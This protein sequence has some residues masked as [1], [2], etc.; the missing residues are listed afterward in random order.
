MTRRLTKTFKRFIRGCIPYAL[1]RL[2]HVKSDRMVYY[3]YIIEHGDAHHLFLFR[4]E[5]DD[6]T[7]ELHLDTGSGLFYT[8]LPRSHKKLF[9][10]RG[11]TP[12]K[13]QAL[14]K[15][16]LMEQDARSPHR[17][18]DQI[19]EFAGKVL[20]D[21]GAAEGILSLMAIEQ[22]RHVYLFECE[23]GWDEALQKTFEPWKQ[24]VSIIPK[25]VCNHDD[26]LCLK[27]DTFCQGLPQGPL[28]LKMDIEG[29]ERNALTGAEQL[30]A[31]KENVTFAICTYH[32]SDDYDVIS[33]FL[34]R[35]GCR[36][37]NQTGYFA[38]KLTSVVL[39]GHN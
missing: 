29:M 12:S 38:H 9:F 3:R 37:K 11:I 19:D 26:D 32:R 33:S 21:V 31:E 5:Y 35:H 4:H 28:F 6:F 16:L 10:K 20:L 24:K 22:V 25:C 14:F 27:L 39:R 36:F 34:S 30:F 2:F 7:P 17:Y 18:F 23:A 1:C 13:A 8:L 15:A